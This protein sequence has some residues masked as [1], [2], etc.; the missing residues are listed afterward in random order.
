MGRFR[1]GFDMDVSFD[2]RS[3]AV[4]FLVLDALS[5]IPMSPPGRFDMIT[6]CFDSETS[7][8]S[9]SVKSGLACFRFP[10]VG[11]LA[12]GALPCLNNMI[13]YFDF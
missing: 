4:T 12:A 9:C 5:T 10:W 7:D 11:L 3:F 8:T 2:G 13:F 1:N 6:Q